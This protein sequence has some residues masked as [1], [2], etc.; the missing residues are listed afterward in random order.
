M[1]EAPRR[2]VTLEGIDGSGKSTLSS[3][4]RRL[5]EARGEQALFTREETPTF[6]GE[7]VKR[8]IEE[9][10]HPLTTCYLFLADRAEH[11]REVVPVLADGR[12]VVSDRYHD[13]TR[14]YQAVT[15]AGFF[16][17]VEAYEA[18]LRLHTEPWLVVPERTYLIDV[19]AEVAGGRL[20]AA[21]QKTTAYEKVAFLDKV[22]S[23]YLRI[24]KEE[25]ER[26]MV[27]DGLRTPDDL[28]A[29]VI[30]DLEAT[31]LLAR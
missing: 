4:L 29:A 17:S 22:R 11:L 15:L 18:W 23:E 26:I 2:F 16:H 6:V 7:A 1:A 12:L 24:A 10:M 19:P 30:A 3:A 25:P 9:R 5:L 20:E 31:G 14:A 13:S 21:R 27:L 28:A 8:S